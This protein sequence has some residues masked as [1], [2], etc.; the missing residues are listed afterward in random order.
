MFRLLF[1][2]VHRADSKGMKGDNAV[3]GIALMMDTERLP[4]HLADLM[5]V[6]LCVDLKTCFSNSL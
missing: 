1:F 6:K 3:L 5:Y 4:K 2:S